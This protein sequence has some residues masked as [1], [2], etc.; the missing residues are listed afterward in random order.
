MHLKFDMDLCWI[1]VPPGVHLGTLLP[2]FGDV[3]SNTFLDQMLRCKFVG[4]SSNFGTVLD[5]CFDVFSEQAGNLKIAL[6]LQRE[7]RSAGSRASRN[8]YLSVMFLH[9]FLEALWEPILEG[10]GYNFSSLFGALWHTFGH[11]LFIRIF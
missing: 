2:H 1:L 6:P 4:F 7:P 11:Q 5:D 9:V 3:F 10:Y 8:L